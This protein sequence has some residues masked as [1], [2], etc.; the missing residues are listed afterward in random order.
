[1]KCVVNLCLVSHLQS[2]LSLVTLIVLLTVLSTVISTV[3][4]FPST[5][6]LVLKYDQYCISTGVLI[7]LYSGHLTSSTKN[8]VLL[9]FNV[10]HSRMHS[11]IYD[12]FFIQR[13]YEKFQKIRPVCSLVHLQSLT[14]G[15]KPQKDWPVFDP[16]RRS[17]TQTLK[18][19]TKNYPNNPSVKE[20][21]IMSPI[22]RSERCINMAVF[23]S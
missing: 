9:C 22:T 14:A 20:D 5:L 8:E 19:A 7:C 15:E 13:K 21:I 4:F 2:M 11:H 17:P 3:I 10:S 1:M 6:M 18:P 16:L 12:Q 23:Y